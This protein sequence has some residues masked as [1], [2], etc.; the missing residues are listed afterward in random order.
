MRAVQPGR[1]VVSLVEPSFD[2]ACVQDVL[3][4]LFVSAK[5]FLD[6]AILRVNANAV[7]RAFRLDR[8]LTERLAAL[9]VGQGDALRL[10]VN[11][12]A[13][14]TEFLASI[15]RPVASARGPRRRAIA[16]PRRPRP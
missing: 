16:A 10:V 11:R 7:P 1:P 12:T 6:G 5:P 4:C 15:E 14:G 3:L 13:A 2:E 9:G 8:A